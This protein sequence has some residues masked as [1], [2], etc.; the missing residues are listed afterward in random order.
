MI[1]MKREKILA[2]TA[3]TIIF[4]AI[5]YT[6]I[7]KP[8]IDSLHRSRQD[9]QL[10]ELKLLKLKEDFKVK[11]QIDEIYT[12]IEPLMH[13]NGTDQQEI[14]TFTQQL[15]DLYAPLKVK[16]RSV[17]ILPIQKE[18]FYRKLFI[19][20]EMSGKVKRIV[21]FITAMAAQPEP[22]K[23]EQFSLQAKEIAD[24][25]GSTFLIS[26]IVTQEKKP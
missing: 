2:I 9:R 5:L 16:I 3:A 14:S 10:L 24:T 15:N 25:I 13:S 11:D 17:K 4:V 26:K 1:N 21:G 18:P 20:I 19:K 23:I 22:I 8:Q 7:V 6:V 12:R